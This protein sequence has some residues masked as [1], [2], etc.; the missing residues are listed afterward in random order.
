MA[1]NV[2][3]AMNPGGGWSVQIEGDEM[4]SPQYATQIEAIMAGRRL[5][6]AEKSKLLINDK[7]GQ[8]RDRHNYDGVF[9]SYTR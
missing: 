5:A 2:H 1:R 9:K 7:S 8:I 3:V 6:M 4:A